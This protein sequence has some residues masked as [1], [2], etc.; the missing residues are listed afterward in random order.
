[1]K[2]DHSIA[3]KCIQVSQPIGSFYIGAIESRDLVKIATADI[4]R[5]KKREVEEYIGIERD[6]SPVRVSE[7]KQYVN[8]VDASFPTSV[9]LAVASDKAE[10]NAGD[11]VMRIADEEDVAKIIDGQHRIAG[12]EAFHGESFQM[13]ATIFV[14]MDME[15]QAI[16]FAT[17]NLKQTKV[18][19]S[20]AYDLYDYA[21]ARS[22]QK[23]CHNIA[24]LLNNTAESPFLDRIKILGV[25]TGKPAETLT[26]ATFVDR[27][28]KYISRDVMKDRDDLKRGRKLKQAEGVDSDRLIF[29]NLFVAERDAEIAK[30]MWNYFDA[31]RRRW[32]RAWNTVERGNVLNRTTGFGALMRLLRRAYIKLAA[33]GPIPKS[34]AFLALFANVKLTD[35]SFTPDR[36]LPGSSGEA[37]LYH[38]LCEATGLRD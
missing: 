29:R 33:K 20:L 37:D 27:L 18:S 4:R 9:I 30:I 15:D 8:T 34:E 28:I 32:P 2:A 21:V 35:D 38:L 5:I 25:A 12:L 24:K 14:D 1:M 26:Q 7:L 36:F 6:L 23:T 22:P 17:I 16:V 11:G 19:K 13:I 31:V 3:F 10:Y